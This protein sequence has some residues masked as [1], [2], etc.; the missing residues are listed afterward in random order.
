MT[1]ASVPSADDHAIAERANVEWGRAINGPHV[2]VLA[3]QMARQEGYAQGLAAA[4]EIAKAHKP[5]R[6]IK[7]VPLLRY[8][9]EDREI[10][11]AEENG[12]AIAAECIAFA[13][14]QER[15]RD[16]APEPSTQT[17]TTKKKGE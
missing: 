12:E 1:G 4:A 3:A 14:L 11:R 9:I 10:I 8:D 6:I 17:H 15:E 5:S 16:H 7:G 13:I 2:A